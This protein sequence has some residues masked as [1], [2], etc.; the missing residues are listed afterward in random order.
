MRA[1]PEAA[2]ETSGSRRSSARSAARVNFSPTTDPIDPPR[3]EKS[4]TASATGVPPIAAAPTT[5][6]SRRPV[7]PAPRSSRSGYGRES[8]NSSGSDDSRSAANSANVPSS[9]SCTIRSR[10]VTGKWWP[11]FVHTRRL[12]TISSSR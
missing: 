5:T 1:P 8:T 3:N 10:A 11:Q 4:I 9:T 6:A 7:A 2:T 12:R